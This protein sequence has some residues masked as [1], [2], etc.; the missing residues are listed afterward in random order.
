MQPALE[1]AAHGQKDERD[2]KSHGDDPPLSGAAG[3]TD[4]SRKPGAGGAGEAT[5]PELMLGTDNDAGAE[6][7]DAGEDSLNGPAGGVG[8]F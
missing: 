5:N 3:D 4:A 1:P 8:K 2:R 7:T 6:K